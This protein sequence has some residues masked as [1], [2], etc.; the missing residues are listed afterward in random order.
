MIAITFDIQL[1]GD[2]A[3]PDSAWL[4]PY[5]RDMML[6]HTRAQITAH[7]QR[8]LAG[9]TCDTHGEPPVVTI[10]GTYDAH[11][12]TLDISYDVQTCCRLFLLRCISALNRR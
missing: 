12:E 1:T 6:D 5:E 9:M 7:V 4:D 10:S 3:D 2:D 11:T 8:A